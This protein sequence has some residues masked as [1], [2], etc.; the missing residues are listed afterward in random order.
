MQELQE[1]E[2]ELSSRQK[3]LS[4]LIERKN[5]LEDDFTRLTTEY[6]RVAAQVQAL[7]RELSHSESQYNHTYSS[8]TFPEPVRAILAG[9][10]GGKVVSGLGTYR[11][12]PVAN[13]A[14]PS[15][16][17]ANFCRYNYDKDEAKTSLDIIL[18]YSHQKS[19]VDYSDE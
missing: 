5:S 2:A 15:K 13:N 6:Q 17:L 18:R 11:F 12:Q 19:R 14:F 4:R 1:L 10:S 8:G 7:R 3:T 16:L 9:Y